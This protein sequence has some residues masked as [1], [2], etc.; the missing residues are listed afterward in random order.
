MAQKVSFTKELEIREELYEKGEI[1]SKLSEAQDEKS[2]E[3]MDNII[4]LEGELQFN[5]QQ[6]KN[7]L[8]TWKKVSVQL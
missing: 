4:K 3:L 8:R 6:L 5:F 7:I 2:I 1:L